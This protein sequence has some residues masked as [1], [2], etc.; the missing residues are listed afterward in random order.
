MV[1]GASTLEWIA[2]HPLSTGRRVRNM[3]RFFQW[4]LQ[5]RISRGPRVFEF[6]NGSRMFAKS[7]MTGATGNLYVG[8]HEFEEMAFLLHFLRSNDLFIDVGANVGSFTILAGAAIGASVIAFEP[9]DEAF[10]WLTRNIELNEIASRVEARH[11]AVGATSGIVSFTSGLDT[12]NRIDPMGK[13]SV[14]ITT[15][16]AVCSRIP[17]LIKIDVEGFEADV[18]RGA[19]NIMASPETQ[20]IIMEV[21]DIAATQ[22]AQGLGFICCDYDPFERCIAARRAPASGNGI[23]VK[24][25]ERSRSRLQDAPTFFVQG[26]SL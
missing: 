17:V 8:L 23:F 10:G 20:A 11:E 15:L 21:N 2:K 12:V 9:G 24:D 16:N 26:R 5:S 3:A 19:D 6:V 7:G 14:P 1:S 13:D 18:L 22:L 4:Q 25:I